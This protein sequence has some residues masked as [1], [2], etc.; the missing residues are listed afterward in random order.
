M[1]R[2][3]QWFYWPKLSTNFRIGSGKAKFARLQCLET[4]MRQ[5]GGVVVF[6]G[7]YPEIKNH[8]FGLP[9]GGG[10]TL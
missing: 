7:E 3:T 2:R 9:G 4:V 8:V 6:G 1:R 5:D 10:P